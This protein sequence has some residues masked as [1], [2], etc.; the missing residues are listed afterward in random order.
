LSGGIGFLI[1]SFNEKGRSLT[2]FVAG[3][4]VVYGRRRAENRIISDEKLK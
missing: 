4:V 3:T 2:D 1:A